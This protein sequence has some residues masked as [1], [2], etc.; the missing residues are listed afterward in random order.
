MLQ[1][2]KP[3]ACG[4]DDAGAGVRAPN[5]KRPMMLMMHVGEKRMLT[6]VAQYPT[7][8]GF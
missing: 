3:D 2:S 5:N 7:G 1:C 8:S 4:D 6:V